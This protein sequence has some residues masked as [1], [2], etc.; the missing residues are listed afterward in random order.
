MMLA[1]PS[2]QPG[3]LGPGCRLPWCY[4]F[5]LGDS[6]VIQDP[7]CQER[8]LHG[9]PQPAWCDQQPQQSGK[10]APFFTHLVINLY[11]VDV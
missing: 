5:S 3:Y 4:P 10:D 1:P 8:V 7:T 2:P 9:L 6:I 11:Y